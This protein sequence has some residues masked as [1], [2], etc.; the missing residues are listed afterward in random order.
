M[1]NSFFF[2]SLIGIFFSCNLDENEVVTT[3]T[4]SVWKTENLKSEVKQILQYKS[5]IIDIKSGAVSSPKI[6]QKKDYSSFGEILKEEYFDAYGKLS[7]Y[8]KNEYDNKNR[9]KKSISNYSEIEI[10]KYDENDNPTSTIWNFKNIGKSSSLL[11]Y[12]SS[13][14]L[15]S[16]IDVSDLGDT[17]RTSYETRL[18][19]SD[20]IEWQKEIREEN[21]E[22]IVF[23]REYDYNENE[24]IKE[25]NDISIQGSIR[26]VYEYRTSGELSKSI[27]YFSG[28]KSSEVEYD[29][30]ENPILEKI[31]RE[32]VLDRE[33]KYEYTYDERNNWIERKVF[34]NKFIEK[35]GEFILMFIETRKI[36]YFK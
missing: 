13:G 15:L 6:S 24:K 20:Q 16:Q 5:D 1:K 19:D 27:G 2:L 17:I 25:Y 26:S 10:L 12:D 28:K 8:T 29:K 3:E 4:D 23:E 9:L 22:V 33:V 18:G 34:G 7:E 32:D 11:N 31:Y 35:P 30:L 21:G 14:N 36:S